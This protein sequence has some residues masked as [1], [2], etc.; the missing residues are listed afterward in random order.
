MI[1]KPDFEQVRQRYEAWWNGEILD[2]PLV[3]VTAPLK[4]A[5]TRDT[6]PDAEGEALLKW[7][8]DAEI[9]IP[10][11]ERQVERT[12]YAGDALPLVFPFDV[13]LPAIETAYLG[14]PYHINGST[15]W[16]EPVIEDWEK[17][18][19]LKVDL[20]NPWWQI[21]RKLLEAGVEN[22]RGRYVIGSP[23]LQ[24]GGEV[25]VLMR[26][27]QQMA[28][29]LF[30]KPDLVRLALVEEI[31]VWKAYHTAVFELIQHGM[32]G[33]IDWL[34]V[35]SDR[36]FATVEN[37]FSAMISPK[38]FN[39]F[40]LPGLEQ[41][42]EWLDRSIFHLD[43]PGALPHL[44]MLLSLPRLNAIQWVIGPADGE[45][46]DWLP[47]LQKIQRA[48]KGV[49]ANCKKGEV[50]RLLQELDAGKIILTTSCDSPQEANA[51]LKSLV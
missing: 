25:V 35:W 12:Y 41:Q 15:G 33:Y 49:V 9:V 27:T 36:R 17:R 51:L 2:R 23:D 22:A 42:L 29:D 8:T 48:G 24:G 37:D 3:Q 30:D 26:G 4:P 28:L 39:S 10:R 20:K 21:T 44:D 1:Y 7:F 31:E 6:L 13:G 11:L 16:T 50:K 18:S 38:M 40:F 43:G 5:D 32:P 19:A 34:G 46:L 45:M 47:L 14:C